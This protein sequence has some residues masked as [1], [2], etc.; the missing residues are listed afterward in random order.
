MYGDRA[1]EAST[2]VDELLMTDDAFRKEEIERVI[3]P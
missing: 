1:L 3:G 2:L